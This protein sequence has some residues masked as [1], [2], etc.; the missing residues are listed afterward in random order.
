MHEPGFPTAP[1]NPQFPCLVL[2]QCL[3]LIL[4]LITSI[5]SGQAQVPEESAAPG[6]QDFVKAEGLRLRA[7]DRDP[8]TEEEWKQRR[9]QL[10]ENL[11]VPG[12]GSAMNAVT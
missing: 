8:Q 10:R 9:E 5:S 11:R 12:A 2:I 1:P 4:W 3:V 7:D 6:F